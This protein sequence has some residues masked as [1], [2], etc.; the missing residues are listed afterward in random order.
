MI[1]EI[2][3]KIIIGSL[4]HLIIIL[5]IKMFLIHQSAVLMLLILQ[6]SQINLPIKKL[7]HQVNLLRQLNLHKIVIIINK[8]LF[9]VKAAKI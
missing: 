1:A 3:K 8:I 6:V 5:K 4:E 7:K 9:K 2:K